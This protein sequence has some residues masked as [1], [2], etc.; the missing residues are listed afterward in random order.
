MYR[1]NAFLYQWLF[2]G[3]PILLA[4]AGNLMATI[5]LIWN[6]ITIRRRL[7]SLSTSWT[8][9]PIQQSRN[10]SIIQRISMRLRSSLSPARPGAREST[11]PSSF[12]VPRRT[13]RHMPSDDMLNNLRA[14]AL[15]YIA[16]FVFV[17]LC[18]FVYRILVQLKGSG[19]F[20]L[21]FIAR[22]L[23]PLQGFFNV[24][25][26]T[27][28]RISRLRSTSNISWLKAFWL[29]ISRPDGEV[30]SSSLRTSPRSSATRERR[31][32]QENQSNQTTT[33]QSGDVNHVNEDED[34]N[35]NVDN[36]DQGIMVS[37]K[38]SI[39][40]DDEN[41]QSHEKVLDS[42]EKDHEVSED[43]GCIIEDEQNNQDI[44][45]LYTTS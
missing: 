40:V 24:L 17:Y 15:L 8:R 28:I 18:S 29:I 25:I 35:D 14:Q 37:G 39:S 4:F 13:S 22:I 21:V 44:E 19:P 43:N 7:S 38:P 20:F 26:Y 33:R 30:G 16:A 6:L 42:V 12:T 34:I 36:Q 11:T 31:S 2:A 27:R 9:P 41:S 45:R 3:G 5:L 10:G 32:R 1:H 23:N